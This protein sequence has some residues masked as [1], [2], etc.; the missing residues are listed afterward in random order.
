MKARCP[1]E[2][3][4]DDSM[5][6]VHAEGRIGAPKFE[7]EMFSVFGESRHV[8]SLEEASEEKAM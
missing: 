3:V 1:P 5:R 4:Y 7:L 2:I 8:G 6:V